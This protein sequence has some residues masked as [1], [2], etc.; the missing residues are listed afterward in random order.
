MRKI[1]FTTAFAAALALGGTAMAADL[2]GQISN[3]RAEGGDTLFE[4]AGKQFIVDDS[5]AK[6]SGMGDLTDGDNVKVSFEDRF[7]DKAEGS[8]PVQVMAIE[9]TE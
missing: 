6:G 3:V 4:L 8:G 7:A 1:I 2:E 9:K 5:T